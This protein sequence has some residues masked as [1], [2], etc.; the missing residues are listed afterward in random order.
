MSDSLTSRVLWSS[1]AIFLVIGVGMTVQNI[2]NYDGIKVGFEKKMAGLKALRNL[3]SDMARYESAKQKIE[4]LGDKRPVPLNTILQETLPGVKVDDVRDSRK[5]LVS[6]WIVRQKEIS[7]SDVPIG[8]VMDFVHK[9]ESQ[10]I[11]WCLTRCV[12]RAAPRA[13][14]SGQVILLMEAVEKAE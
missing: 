1:A 8:N 12:I 13:A 6:G 11:P 10:K 4:Q 5:E 3:E 9:A 7:I 14:G 2:R